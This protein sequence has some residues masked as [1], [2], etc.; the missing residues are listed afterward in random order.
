MPVIVELLRVARRRIKRLLTTDDIQRLL[1]VAGPRERVLLSVL[2]STGIRLDEALHLKWY[3]LDS[4][5]FSLR[6]S[7]KDGWTPKNHQE[8]TVYVPEKVLLSPALG[9]GGGSSCR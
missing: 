8:R 4:R 1:S 2:G 9:Q 6:L 7:A 3:D 5:D